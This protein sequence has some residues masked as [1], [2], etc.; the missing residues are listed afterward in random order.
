MSGQTFVSS[1]QIPT[2]ACARAHTHTHTHTHTYTPT[3]RGCDN[4]QETLDALLRART[5]GNISF[6]EKNHVERDLARPVGGG[7]EG[8]G[9]GGGY[10]GEL[11]KHIAKDNAPALHE[12]V[13]ETVYPLLH[14]G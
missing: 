11:T 3:Q 13:P 4:H 1:V 2:Y 5:A 7:G 9:N 10:G 8:G 6:G 14:V 12:L